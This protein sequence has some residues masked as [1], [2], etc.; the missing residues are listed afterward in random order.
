MST[1]LRFRFNPEKLV[2]AL[3]FFATHELPYLSKLKLAK[4]LYFADKYHLLRYGRPI[5][6]DQ[7]Y[8]LPL[9]PLPSQADNFM[10]EAE[11]SAQF[12]DVKPDPLFDEYLWIDTSLKYPEFRAKRECN[13]EVFSESEL[14]ALRATVREYGARSPMELVDLTHQQADYELANRGRPPHAR[15]DMPYEFFFEGQPAEVQRVLQQARVE[16][17]DR[18]FAEAL[19]RA[20]AE[21]LRRG[22]TER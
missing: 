16:Q 10:D 17:E 21:A 18:D 12:D 6:G 14:E 9:G 1:E 2:Q 13:L 11:F 15:S 19:S 7:Y 3:A 20:G 22:H 8:C 4:L 5:L